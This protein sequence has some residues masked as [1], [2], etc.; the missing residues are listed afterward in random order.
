MPDMKLIMESWDEF[1]SEQ[2][3]DRTTAADYRA[4]VVGD[5][6]AAGTSG[7]VDDK[8][9]NLLLNLQKKLAA[10]AKIDNIASGQIFSLADRLSDHLDAILQKKQPKK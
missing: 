4:H 9:R 10:V 6:G 5:K 2:S 3:A 7:G 8:E 1:V